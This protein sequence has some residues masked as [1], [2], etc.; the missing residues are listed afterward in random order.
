MNDV[1]IT[2]NDMSRNRY[3]S[4]EDQQWQETYDKKKHQF[5]FAVSQSGGTDV[6]WSYQLPVEL[7]PG[8]YRARVWSRRADLINNELDGRFV[9]FIYLSENPEL[10]AATAPIEST[11]TSPSEGDSIESDQNLLG[12]LIVEGSTSS[13]IGVDEIVAMVF[14]PNR[15]Q[16]WNPDEA[17]WQDTFVGFE[18]PIDENQDQASWQYQLTGLE[19]GSYSV[20]VRGANAT[21]IEELGPTVSFTVD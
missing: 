16:Y 11:I 19:P 13:N 17:S 4:D 12:S 14:D 5:P 9:E 21:G 1:F 6:G 10:A 3:W 8:R 18:I 15:R 7:E 2:I 20:S